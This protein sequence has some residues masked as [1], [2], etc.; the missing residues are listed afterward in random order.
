[1][2]SVMSYDTIWYSLHKPES[3]HTI[4]SSG[5][6]SENTALHRKAIKPW[7]WTVLSNFVNFALDVFR[8]PCLEVSQPNV[9]LLTRSWSNARR[10][11]HQGS[12]RDESGRFYL[13]EHVSASIIWVENLERWRQES[14]RWT[15]ESI[16]MSRSFS[17][18]FVRF[19]HSLTCDHGGFLTTLASQLWS[20]QKESFSSFWHVF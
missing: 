13:W 3:H 7:R 12:R 19:C 11:I 18:H 4:V 9:R 1:M 14:S 2:S 6:L 10:T 5:P 8:C 16:E 15:Q 17:T 20:W